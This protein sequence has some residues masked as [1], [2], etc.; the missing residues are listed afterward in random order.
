M[1]RYLENMLIN[2]SFALGSQLDTATQI[3]GGMT[4]FDEVAH[5]MLKELLNIR[6]I[7]ID[8]FVLHVIHSIATCSEN[9]DCFGHSL[10]W[11]GW[12]WWSRNLGNL[13]KVSVI[14]TFTGIR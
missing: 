4:H 2:P 12:G 10:V 8:V 3:N 1:I 14:L 7:P 6:V 13:H 9:K 5:I 11:H